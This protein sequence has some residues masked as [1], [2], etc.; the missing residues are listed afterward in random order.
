MM[1]H[2]KNEVLALV[3]LL[4]MTLLVST[5]VS[6]VVAQEG[7]QAS[8]TYQLNMRTG[9]G[10][11]YDT[12][13]VLPGGVALFL[14]ARNED[15]SWVLARTADGTSRGWVASLYLTYQPGFSATRL[16]VS[17]EVIGA[18]AP[19]QPAP[20]AANPVQGA[21]PPD[22]VTAYTTY[23]LNVR[24]GP[25]TNYS[26]LGKLPGDTGLVLEAR[27]GDASFVLAHTPDGSTRGWLASLYLR[28]VGVSAFNLPVS[29]ETISV[30]LAAVSGVAGGDN[31]S[32]QDIR[33]GGYDP[34]K[35]V[36]IDLT[37]FPVVGGSTAR[38]REI[39]WA[40]KEQGNNPNVIAKV[41]DCSSEHWYFL[42]P[43][44][45]G[46]YNLGAY[47]NLLPAINHF[48]ESLAYN[49]QATH[50]GFNVNAVLAPEWSDPSAC[51]AGES[52][53]QCEFRL[54]KPGV[55]VIMFGTSDLLVMTPYEFDFY[56]RQIVTESIEAGVIPILSTFP[57]NQAFPNH[58]IVYNQV[59]VRIALDFD[60]PLINLWLALEA[61]PNQGLEPDGFHLGE[62]AYGTACFLTAPYTSTGYVTRNLVTLQ[63]LDAV[64]R[65]AM[66]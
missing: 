1:L 25:G 28:F 58:T 39:F 48:G 8:T 3:G 41:G 53:L 17:A 15:V 26:A 7:P 5:G 66:Q 6:A 55:V 31:V 2:R 40:G 37:A 56:M 29:S 36:G 34:A 18:P 11:N 10:T 32:Y 22:G 44:A 46:Q 13:S 4:I 27:N 51:Q 61:L 38:A 63:T 21:P 24:S 54:H 9:P 64:W 23:E 16:P 19:A 62:P 65:G 12:I 14:E 43:F 50:N 35:I 45:W 33:M 59:V 60:I 42:S 30:S 52:P 57:G 20:E 49:S 47:S